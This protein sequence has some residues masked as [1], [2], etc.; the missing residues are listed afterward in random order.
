MFSSS[1]TRPVVLAGL[2]TLSALILMVQGSPSTLGSLIDPGLP[3]LITAKV[4]IL[5]SFGG[6]C[7]ALVLLDLF[8]AGY[9][10]PRLHRSPPH[11]SAAQ[12]QSP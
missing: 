10:M 4:G 3:S 1:S 9:A 7:L 8:G 5:P 2:S 11:I 12:E 6:I